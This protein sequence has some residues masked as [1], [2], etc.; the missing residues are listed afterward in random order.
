MPD[1]LL[2]DVAETKLTVAAGSASE[3]AI[4]HIALGDG[5]GATY[6][7]AHAQTALIR[8]RARVPVETRHFAGDRTWRVKAEFPP[9]TVAFAVREMGFFDADGDLIAV[10]AGV[11]V[12]PRQ[13]GVVTYLV[14]HVLDFS[15]VDDGLIIVDAPDDDLFDLAVITGIGFANLQTEQLRQADRIRAEHGEY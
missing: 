7:P 12:D 5:N 11:D 13:T 4:T 1:T 10:W 8:E 6:A 9:T 3:V 2:T 15:R 14:E